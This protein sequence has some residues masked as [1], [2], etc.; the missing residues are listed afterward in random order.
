MDVSFADPDLER[1]YY[2]ANYTAGHAAPVVR[3]YRDIVLF[4]SAARDEHD[5]RAWQSLDLEA[6][7]PEV[8]H[9]WS[10][11]LHGGWR[12]ILDRKEGACRPGVVVVAVVECE[13]VTSQVGQ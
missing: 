5:L 4:I 11:P 1:V 2:D 3:A 13:L 9:D 10:V 12:L 7:P 8:G 6:L